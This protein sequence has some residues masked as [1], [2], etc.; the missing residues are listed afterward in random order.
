MNDVFTLT[1]G[2]H[3]V[4]LYLRESGAKLD[5]LQMA[6]DGDNVS[7]E[8]EPNAC[9]LLVRQLASSPTLIV[10]SQT[11]STKRFFSIEKREEYDGIPFSDRIQKDR[12]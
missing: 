3:T 2:E 6:R 7:P 8:P 12:R 5:L 10:N 1:P 4:T 11:N 9:E